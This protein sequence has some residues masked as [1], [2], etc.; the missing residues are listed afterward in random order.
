M[1]DIGD[2]GDALRRFRIRARINQEAIAR[3]L[4][5]SQGQISRWESGRDAPRAHNAEAIRALVWGRRDE[6]VEA[7]LAYV[8]GAHGPLALFDARLDIV[9]ASPFLRM[10]GGPLAQFGWLFDAA[11]N[12]VLA[13]MAQRFQ[14][15]ARSEAVIALAIPFT[16]ED[17]PWACRGR[18]SVAA[19]ASEP[20]AIGE[21][22]FARDPRHAVTTITLEASGVVPARTGAENAPNATARAGAMP[23]RTG[24]DW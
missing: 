9:A 11:I 18:L 13:T 23:T 22:S 5:V 14:R 15:L 2:L 8:E 10:R 4:G 3:T 20:Y 21:M 7:L 6:Q 17:E 16:H 19:V 1:S 12:P 24:P